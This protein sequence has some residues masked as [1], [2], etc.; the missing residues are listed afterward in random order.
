MV[1]LLGTLSMIFFPTLESG[2]VHW[3]THWSLLYLCLLGVLGFEL[4]S[5]KP[6]REMSLQNFKWV[7]FRLL[8][9]GFLSAYPET[10]DAIPNE[11]SKL[12]PCLT[13]CIDKEPLKRPPVQEVLDTL[14]LPEVAC[15][16]SC[17]YVPQHDLNGSDAHGEQGEDDYAGEE[18]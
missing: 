13:R 5:F 7:L 12:V 6:L 4:L 10:R 18:I 1:Y 11:A 8:A 16:R 3:L 17:E 9:G 15:L 2:H 14:Q